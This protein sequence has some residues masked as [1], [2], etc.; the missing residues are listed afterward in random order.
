M[1]SEMEGAKRADEVQRIGSR[2]WL[3]LPQAAAELQVS[4]ALLRRAY[5]RGEL[6]AHLLT[7]RLRIRRADLQ[8]WLDSTRWTPALCHE[9][10]ARPRGVRTNSTRAGSSI[11]ARDSHTAP[12]VQ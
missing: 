3:T 11:G 12:E 2:D 7:N 6:V 5:H 10:T 8:A 1:K 9:R 4:Q